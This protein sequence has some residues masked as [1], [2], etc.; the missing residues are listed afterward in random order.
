MNHQQTP[1]TYLELNLQRLALRAELEK[2]DLLAHDAQARER[3]DALKKAQALIDAFGL[4]AAEL[5]LAKAKSV[6]K[7][8]TTTTSGLGPKKFRHPETGAEWSGRGKAPAWIKNNDKTLFV[9][10]AWS[11]STSKTTLISQPTGGS[12][13]SDLPESAAFAET[14]GATNN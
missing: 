11:V 13:R 10:P 7:K 3:G 1:P 9:N 8:S 4:T 5:Q 12:Q 6:S 2:L 14:H